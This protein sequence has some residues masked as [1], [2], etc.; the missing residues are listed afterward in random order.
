MHAVFGFVEDDGGGRLE[1]LIGDFHAGK[2]EFFV[3]VATDGGLEVV[4]GGKTVHEA[5]LGTCGF[6]EGGVDA[7]GGEV[8]DALFPDLGGLA[9]GDPNVGVDDVGVLDGNGRIFY[10]FKRC[11]GFGGDSLT[12]FYQRPVG[13]IFGGRTGY[14]VHSHLGTADHQGVAHVVAGVTHVDQLAAGESSEMLADGQEIGKDLGGMELVGQAVP[15]GNTCVSG[16]LLNQLLPKAAVLDA[17]KHTAQHPRRIGNTL[18]FADLRACGIK[19]YG[20]MGVNGFWEGRIGF[21]KSPK[22]DLLVLTE[23]FKFDPGRI[24]HIS[25]GSFTLPSNSVRVFM[26]IDG[27]VALEI[28][29]PDPIDTSTHGFVG[30]EAFCTKV[31]Y[32]NLKIK[33]LQLTDDYKTYTPEF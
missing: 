28:T 23:M 20:V 8:A 17:V 27:V 15:H 4:E 6:H 18:L 24:Y 33:R 3:N 30:F 12:L 21:E 16:Q 11:T 1:D 2:T 5:A 13:E 7:V 32:K 26:A 29:D 22:Y 10:K 14:K 31:K 9:H 19:V 25:V